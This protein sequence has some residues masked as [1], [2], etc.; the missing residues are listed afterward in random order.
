M[1]QRPKITRLGHI[2]RFVVHRGHVPKPRG[3]EAGSGYA[4]DVGADIRSPSG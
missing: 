3:R 2:R 4:A 1:K